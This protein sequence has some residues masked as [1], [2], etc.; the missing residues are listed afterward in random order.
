VEGEIVARLRAL[1]I[2]AAVLWVQDDCVTV[3]ALGRALHSRNWSILK[4]S[5]SC[6]ATIAARVSCMQINDVDSSQC[7]SVLWPVPVAVKC[8][9]PQQP[10][11]LYDCS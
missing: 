6:Q 7:I 9:H 4:G 10:Y 8:F 5:F 3:L 1:R 11:L 2:H